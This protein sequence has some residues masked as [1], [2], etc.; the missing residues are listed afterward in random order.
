MKILELVY[1]QC[2]GGK[3]TPL[4]ITENERERADSDKYFRT[5]LRHYDVNI[6]V[7]LSSENQA[8][9]NEMLNNSPDG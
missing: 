9:H 1:G 7:Y 2:R 3:T 8:R 5:H 6:R 4:C